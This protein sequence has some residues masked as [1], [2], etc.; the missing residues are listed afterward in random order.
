MTASDEGGSQIQK[1]DSGLEDSHNGGSASAP[2]E[3]EQRESDEDANSSQRDSEQGQISENGGTSHR[4]GSNGMRV[5][6]SN[7]F[8]SSG[9]LPSEG[10]VQKCTSS[11]LKRWENRYLRLTRHTLLFCRDDKDNKTTDLVSLEKVE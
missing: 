10:W 7:P 1:K 9:E 8:R 2:H 5:D 3:H 11:A 6:S 4:K